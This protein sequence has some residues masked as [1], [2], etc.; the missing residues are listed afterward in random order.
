MGGQL[1]SPPPQQQDTQS[2]LIYS[3]EDIDNTLN[4]IEDETEPAWN[5]NSLYDRLEP[6]PKKTVN[7]QPEA[8]PIR[9]SSTS[10]GILSHLKSRSRSPEALKPPEVSKP[11]SLHQ[12]MSPPPPPPPKIPINQ[13]VAPPGSPNATSATA[14]SDPANQKRRHTDGNQKWITTAAEGSSGS[15]SQERS[16]DVGNSPVVRRQH[17]PNADTSATRNVVMAWVKEQQSK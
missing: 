13:I 9:S 1:Q 3:D 16:I 5:S 8:L 4:D 10:G 2:H 11:P 15:Q 7:K 12:V 14:S 17:P 6:I